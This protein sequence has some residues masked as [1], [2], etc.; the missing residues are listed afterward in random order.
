M[1]EAP[2]PVAVQFPVET[3]SQVEVRFPEGAPSLAGTLCPAEVPYLAGALCSVE[4]PF[5]V[6]APSRAG[7][8]SPVEVPCLAGAL[9][10]VETPFQVEVRFPVEVPSPA[11]TLSPEGALSLAGT[12]F[13]IGA[14]P[15]VA[16]WSPLATGAAGSASCR[17][18]ASSRYRSDRP[19]SAR[20]ARRRMPVSRSC[21]AETSPGASVNGSCADWVFGK[22]ITSRMLSAPAISMTMRSRP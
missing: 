18:P 9:C 3:P 6:E 10:P 1:T 16:T 12:V 11:G 4:T 5:P 19:Y 21:S 2:L 7:T 15:G 14:V 13:P 22:A 8:L 20:G 17:K